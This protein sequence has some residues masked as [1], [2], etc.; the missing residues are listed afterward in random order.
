MSIIK[1]TDIDVPELSIFTKATENELAH[2]NEPHGLGFFIAESKYIINIALDMGYEP[3]LALCD[4]T[5][6]NSEVISRLSDVPIYTAPISVLKSITGF[7][8]TEGFL[9]AMKRKE[10]KAHEDICK[11][12]KRIAVLERVMNPTNVGAII[13]SAAALGID[14]CI[15]TYDCAD[16]F[17][18]RAIRVSR[19]SVFSL[20]IAIFPKDEPYKNIEFL[21]EQ[22]FKTVAMALEKD[23]ISI[24][25]T[26]LCEC[27]KL[28]IVLG[29]EG[30]GLSEKTISACDYTAMIPMQNGI[31]SLNVAAASAVVFWQL[32]K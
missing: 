6:L 12:A 14:A 11:N 22:G 7:N 15:L 13:R 16:P 1:I 21:K 25:D 27:E 2:I 30:D 17:Y 28:A 5:L 10:L 4:D 26:R 9:C 23:S 31:D 20:P 24:K 19:G 29:S 3:I 8:L 18:R 32:G